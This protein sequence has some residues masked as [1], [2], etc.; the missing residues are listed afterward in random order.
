MLTYVRR[1]QKGPYGV[2]RTK[3][4]NRDKTIIKS[5]F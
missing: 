5:V 2:T 1:T 3:E 4:Y